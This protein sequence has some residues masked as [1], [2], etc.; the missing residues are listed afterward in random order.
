MDVLEKD[1][2]VP[3][4]KAREKFFG[5]A[6]CMLCPSPATIEALIR[7]MPEGKLITTELL[8][9]KLAEEA[10]V[11]VTC[12]ATTQ[13]AL[14]YIAKKPGQAIAYWHIVKKNGELFSYFPGG[15]AGHAALL[16]QD[17]FTIDTHGRAPKV[18]DLGENL[19]HFD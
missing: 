17:G 1:E 10:H 9:Q 6:G 8:R 12:P 2:I 4:S 18:A 11:E 14:R 13:K 16:K 7:R 3:I 5:T 15:A 19:V